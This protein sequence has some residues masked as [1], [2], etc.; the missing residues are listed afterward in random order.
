MKRDTSP[1]D[2]RVALVRLRAALTDK[3]V[4]CP[5]EINLFHPRKD[6]YQVMKILFQPVRMCRLIPFFVVLVWYKVRFLCRVSF[7]LFSFPPC[8]HDTIANDIGH[9]KGSIYIHPRKIHNEVI[10]ANKLLIEHLA[11]CAN[12]NYF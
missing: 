7:R 5:Y 9:I 3:K 11:C 10:C 4:S 8:F 12:I 2:N 6:T 1:R